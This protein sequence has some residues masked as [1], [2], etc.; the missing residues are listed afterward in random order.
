MSVATTQRPASRGLSR[1]AT[2]VHDGEWV[3]RV[4]LTGT[5][6]YRCTGC[7]VEAPESALRGAA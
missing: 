5:H 4:T 3:Y 7:D 1:H 2:C 6:W